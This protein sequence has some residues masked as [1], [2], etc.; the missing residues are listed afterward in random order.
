[1]DSMN[2][3]VTDTSPESA[4]R[5]NSLLRNSGIPI[6]VINASKA[7]DIKRSLDQ[8]SPLLV[9]YANPDTNSAG[10]EEVSRL[11]AEYAVPF[12]LYTNFENPA[13]LLEAIKSTACIV[14]N[15]TRESQLPDLVR[16]LMARHA[17]TRTQQQQRSQLEELNHRYELLLNSA[18]DATA[19]IHEGLHV[20]ANRAY[21]TALRVTD[22][23]D[24]AG[25][26]LLEL[27][28]AEGVD[29]KKVFQGLSRGECPNEALEVSITRPDGTS[30]DARL[31]FSPARFNGE[32]CTQMLVHERDAVSGLANELERIRLTDP[33]TQLRNKRSFVELLET[34]LAKPRTLDSVSAI[35]YVEP[36]GLSDL[37]VVLDLEGM[38]ALVADLALVVKS[39][40]GPREE[41]AR[42]SEHGI[43]VLTR[44]ASME[45]VEQLSAKI[46]N[47]YSEH[48]VEIGERS[49]SLSCSIGIATL[50][51][52][53]G[54]WSDVVT[55]AR[56][57]QA[58]AAEAGNGVVVYRPQ[59]TAVSNFID[60]RQWIDRIKLALRNRDFFSV[61]HSIINLEGESECLMENLIY[62]HDDSGDVAAPEFMAIADRNDLAGAIDRLV[63]PG[64]LKSF[65]ETAD[66]QIITISNNSIL[67]Y[68]FPAWLSE[69]M[70]AFCVEGRKLIVQIS[71][72]AVQSNL[73]P[74]QRLMH[75][76]EPLGC[77]LSISGFDAERRTRQLLEHVGAS[78]VKI[79]PSLTQGLVGNSASHEVI[80]NIVD[81][82][83]S[84][85]V[86]VIAD[87]VSDTSS[88]AI[89][90]QCGVKL[91]AGAFLKE[92]SQVVG[93]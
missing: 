13:D 82:A 54:T 53:A 36:D 87:E 9:I 79:H 7:L 77:Q 92:K 84:H 81:A 19:Y 27:M 56:K 49:L 46:L 29:L 66:K 74:V 58:E 72:A 16:R 39:C 60:D 15:S 2:L 17:L 37:K 12:A 28:R 26:S 42:V 47:T 23:S 38:D 76:L 43:A 71:A 4:E 62:L 88:L 48:L 50:G 11:A 89:L 73:K 75:E 90:W 32:A 44:Q 78:Y 83:E 25:L 57:A 21:L 10:I 31:S 34:E 85:S 6:H 30:F 59:L 70:S 40:L 80:R 67:D 68:A 52:L 20:F 18:R 55:G 64:L 14:I 5:I 41:A 86:A 51:R 91:I 22:I 63:I 33:L 93:Q 65:V 45:K 24:I 1:M 3:L 61:Q 69:Q 8:D 35:L